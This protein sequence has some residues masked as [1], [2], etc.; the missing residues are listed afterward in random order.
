[1]SISQMK[2]QGNVKN[3]HVYT[4][5]S[6]KNKPAMHNLQNNIHKK[7]ERIRIIMQKISQFLD[8]FLIWLRFFILDDHLWAFQVS[9]SSCD[10]EMLVLYP[11]NVKFCTLFLDMFSVVL[12]LVW[13]FYQLP[14]LF[15]V[16]AKLVWQFV[17]HMCL[18]WLMLCDCHA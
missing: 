4:N 15:Y 2:N 16:Y 17:S 12:A 11:M 1:L 3:G 9:W 18:S 6:T 8:W 14:F 10:C 13:G 7:L 5:P